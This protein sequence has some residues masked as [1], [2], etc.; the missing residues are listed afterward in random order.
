MDGQGAPAGTPGA[1]AVTSD[2]PLRERL[3][4]RSGEAPDNVVYELRP[5]PSSSLAKDRLLRQKMAEKETPNWPVVQSRA[6]VGPIVEA[7]NEGRELKPFSVATATME[8][9]AS[10]RRFRCSS[11]ETCR[12]HCRAGIW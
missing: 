3:L 5:Y 1:A 10:P 4:N 7:I 8:Q 12:S 2:S 9:Q 6:A 11:S